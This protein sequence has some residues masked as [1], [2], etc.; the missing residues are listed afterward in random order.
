MRLVAS[1]IAALAIV[2]LPVVASAHCSPQHTVEAPQTPMPPA[3]QTTP[4]QTPVPGKTS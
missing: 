3:G 4:P 1:V 2:A